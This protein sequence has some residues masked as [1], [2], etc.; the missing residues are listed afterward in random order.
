MHIKLFTRQRTQHKLFTQDQKK[1]DRDKRESKSVP[2]PQLKAGIFHLVGQAGF[3]PE[4]K[5][6]P[7]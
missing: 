3:K 4:L 1:A 6:H 7:V 5:I 2:G